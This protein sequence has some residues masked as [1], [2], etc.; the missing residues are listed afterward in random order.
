M[1]FGLYYCGILAQGW[2]L[3]MVVMTDHYL[4]GAIIGGI[5]AGAVAVMDSERALA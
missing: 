1:R 2:G 4:I 3:A 5:A